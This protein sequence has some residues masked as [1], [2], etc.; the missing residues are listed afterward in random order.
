MLYH[1]KVRGDFE[2]ARE[3]LKEAGKAGGCG[4]G[5]VGGGGQVCE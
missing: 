2:K 3:V 5:V 4:E 1:R